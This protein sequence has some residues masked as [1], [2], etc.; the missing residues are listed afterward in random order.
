LEDLLKNPDDPCIFDE[1]LPW[2]K[3]IFTDDMFLLRLHYSCFVQDVETRAS[4]SPYVIRFE[5]D[6]WKMNKANINIAMIVSHLEQSLKG[7][8]LIISSDHNSPN[9]MIR[10]RI[11]CEE[12]D[13]RHEIHKLVQQVHT[14]LRKTLILGI[15]ETKL[16][17][18]GSTSTKLLVKKCYVE[19]DK[20]EFFLKTEGSNLRDVMNLPEVDFT[21]IKCNNPLE[22]AQILGIEAAREAIVEEIR[23]VMNFY[24]INVNRRHLNLLAD[25]M[26]N[27][28]VI[29]STTRHGI[30]R[31]DRSPLTKC[32][33][34]ETVKFLLQAAR[35]SS[36]DPLV[37]ISPNIMVGKLAPL[38]TGTF[39]LLYDCSVGDANYL[40]GEEEPDRLDYEEGFTTTESDNWADMV[41]SEATINSGNANANAMHT[42]DD[43][44]L[45]DDGLPKDDAFSFL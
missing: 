45:V 33:F 6:Q 20:N 37:S 25:I 17:M 9:S 44:V 10:V 4:I 30:N 39:D 11:L 7:G 16:K 2:K 5:L 8:A 38:G 43:P 18:V 19:Q 27:R 15:P 13:N 1:P 28:G 31:S 26:T 34:E 23:E 35:N 14:N 36:L 21:R 41:E 29:M 42:C 32:T 40:E 12:L 3:P 24:S 22:I